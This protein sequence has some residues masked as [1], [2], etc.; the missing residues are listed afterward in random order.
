MPCRRSVL[1]KSGATNYVQVTRVFQ[2]I[3]HE[4][5]TQVFFEVWPNFYRAAL[6][7][8]A[9]QCVA[10]IPNRIGVDV[11]L[12]WPPL[13][14]ASVATRGHVGRCRWRERDGLHCG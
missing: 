11:G 5:T 13:M 6:F 8:F 14:T 10:H 3:N 1:N 4:R 7:C 12:V 2:E 9:R